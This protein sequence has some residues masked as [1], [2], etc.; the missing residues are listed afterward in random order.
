MKIFNVTIKGKKGDSIL[1]ARHP[2]EFMDN[3]SD[4]KNLTEKEY[5]GIHAYKTKDGKFYQQAGMIH[6]ALMK[7]SS[8]FEL[9]GK[10]IKIFEDLIKS[11]VII[12]PEE[13]VHKNQ[14]GFAYKNRLKMWGRCV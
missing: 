1:Q 5:F 9:G 6:H 2:I 12:E 10:K 14:K 11:S 8:K 13:I 4:L 7:A 3:P